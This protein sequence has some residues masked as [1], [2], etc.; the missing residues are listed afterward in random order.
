MLTIKASRPSSLCAC[1]SCDPDSRL[2]IHVRTD[3]VSV[4]IRCQEPNL[5]WFL[6]PFIPKLAVASE[7]AQILRP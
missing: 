1:F 4:R 2:A 3:K 6:T 7:S 5:I